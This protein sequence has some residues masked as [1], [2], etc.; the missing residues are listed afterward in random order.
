MSRHLGFYLV[1]ASL[2]FFN[3][4]CSNKNQTL[5]QQGNCNGSSTYSILNKW[6]YLEPGKS[7]DDL[8]YNFKVMIFEPGAGVC[9]TQVVNKVGGAAIYKGLYEHDVSQREVSLSYIQGTNPTTNRS[10]SDDG[11]R[12]SFSGQC[13]NT[14]M[15]LSYDDGKSEVYQLYSVASASGDCQ[16]Q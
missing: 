4:S 15:T 16:I 10:G 5:S 11:V 13:E 3:Q 7:A 2:V 8:E 9:L 12:Y 1:L 6:K 14:K